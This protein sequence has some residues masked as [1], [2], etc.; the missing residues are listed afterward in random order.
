MKEGFFLFF[1]GRRK[2]SVYITKNEIMKNYDFYKSVKIKNQNK[3]ILIL[4]WIFYKTF[5]NDARFLSDKFWFKIKTE[6]WYESVWFPKN[7]LEKYLSE[8]KNWDF[9]YI[10]F[11]KVQ[12]DFI[13]IYDFV[14]NKKLEFQEEN[15]KFVNTKSNHQEKNDFTSFLKDLSKLIEKY[16]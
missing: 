10:V 3:I 5:Q 9:W 11:D 4:S 12:W 8:L 1:D 14:W 15:L 2:I 6:W 7:V 13:K 16:S